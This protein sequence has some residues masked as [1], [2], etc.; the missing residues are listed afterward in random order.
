MRCA[1]CDIQMYPISKTVGLHHRKGG[2]FDTFRYLEYCAV[3]FECPNCTEIMIKIRKEYDGSDD[4]FLVYP[5]SC[6]Y[7]TA[8]KTVPAEIAKDYNEACLV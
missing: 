1:H 7:P 2:N 3:I 5:K 4:S 8:P 6:N